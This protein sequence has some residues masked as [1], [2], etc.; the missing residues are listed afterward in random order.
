MEEIAQACEMIRAESDAVNRQY[1]SDLKDGKRTNPPFS[2]I[3][4]LSLFF[5]VETDYWRVGTDATE[6]TR[7]IEREVELIE[8]G[9]QAA[10]AIQKLDSTTEGSDESTQGTALMGALFRG[11]DG[12]DSGQARAILRL[13]LLGLQG[14][15]EDQTG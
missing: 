4:A 8:L 13:A 9:V 12:A 5:G 3:E 1:L 10:K 6:R 2:I 15:Q 7:Q 11:L 14:A